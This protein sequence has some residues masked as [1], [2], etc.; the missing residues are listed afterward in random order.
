MANSKSILVAI[1]IF[2][3]LLALYFIYLPP[4]EGFST[5]AEKATSIVG[6]FNKNMPGATYT[7]YK[8]DFKGESNLIEY[9]DAKKL[10][11]NND[12]TVSKL[13]EIL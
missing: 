1:I 2:V 7:Q 4:S 5:R 12:L 9:E 3:A 13:Q 8:K 6:W 11:K 10:H